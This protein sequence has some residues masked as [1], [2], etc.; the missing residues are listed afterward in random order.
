MLRLAIP[1]NQEGRQ[2]EENTKRR[3]DV[4]QGRRTKGKKRRR[5]YEKEDDA[6]DLSRRWRGEQFVDML[7]LL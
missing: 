5:E 1:N 2:D 7:L 4:S 6:E 3:E